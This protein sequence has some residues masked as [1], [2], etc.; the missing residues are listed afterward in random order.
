MATLTCF[1]LYASTRSHKGSPNNQIR[2]RGEKAVFQLK[3]IVRWKSYIAR[4][5]QPRPSCQ[6]VL[7]H[8]RLRSQHCPF[9][10]C[11][12]STVAHKRYLCV[13]NWPASTLCPLGPCINTKEKKKKVWVNWHGSLHIHKWSKYVFLLMFSFNLWLQGYI[14]NITPLSHIT[15]LISSALKSLSS[16]LP[17]LTF[18]LTSHIDFL[19]FSSWTRPPFLF[20]RASSDERTP[21]ASFVAC[22]GMLSQLSHCFP[23]F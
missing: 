22:V 13:A 2:R 11:P 15:H 12:M 20:H 5:L 8:K 1:W 9:S 23:V 7:G 6:S 18:L 17:W 4:T 10:A 16:F 14:L 19:L 3:K 21:A